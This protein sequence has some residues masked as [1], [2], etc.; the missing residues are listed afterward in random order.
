LSIQIFFSCRTFRITI[1]IEAPIY[2][3]TPVLGTGQLHIV[4]LFVNISSVV[5]SELC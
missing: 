3:Y 5:P 1:M 4:V 2:A